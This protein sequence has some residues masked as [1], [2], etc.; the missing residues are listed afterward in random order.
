MPPT[1]PMLPPLPP[2]DS[3]EQ[4]AH[5]ALRLAERVMQ[6]LDQGTFTATYKYAVLL[7]MMDLCLER[8]GETG[9]PPDTLT[10]RQLA[11]K[12]IALYWPQ[13]APYVASSAGPGQILLQSG[14]GKKGENTGQG[15][16]E[17]ISAICQFQDTLAR[18]NSVSSSLVRARTLA[19][20]Q[21]WEALVHFVEW[22]L[23]EM[24]LPRLQLMGRQ[25]DCFLYTIH[26][27]LEVRKRGH[28]VSVKKSE[29]SRYQKGDGLAFDNRI[30]LKPG[31][32]EQLVLLNGVLRPLIHR[33]WA[34]QV[35]TVN[36]LEEARLERFLFG[37]QRIDLSPVRDGLRELQNNHCFYCEEP[38][39]ERK[40]ARAPHIDHFIPWARH[41][42]NAIE[43]LVLAH[44]SCNSKKRDFLASAEHVERWQLRTE[45]HGA[46][47][48]N[49]SAP[50]KWESEPMRV[51]SVSRAI[52]W[53]LPPDAR[54]WQLGEAFVPNEPERLKRVL[55]QQKHA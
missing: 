33:Q 52:Y 4:R 21:A 6:L 19:G 17:I 35:A 9:L 1:A 51:L 37:A 44:A 34:H 49:L 7:A 18:N 22:K 40:A 28:E 26:W 55:G 27:H 47:L 20:V 43:N 48:V 2:S 8:T 41:P 25:E 36:N 38:I 16:A 45:Q 3:A 12:V 10:T 13:T 46:S 31:V 14:K 32:A 42:E 23:I 29:V 24:P 54:L 53:R 39:D 50:I 30:L 5:D 11:E 15:Q